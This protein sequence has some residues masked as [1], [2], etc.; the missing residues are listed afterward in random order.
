M[1]LQITSKTL[2]ITG[3]IL[4]MLLQ[5]FSVAIAQEPQLADTT[6][7]CMADS[8]LLDAGDGFISYLWSTDE[9]TQT[10]LAKQPGKYSVICTRQ[11][12]S[13]VEDSTFVIMQNARIDMVDTILTCYSYPVTL[14]V[15]PDTLMYQWTSNDPEL[16][17]PFSTRACVEVTPEK[18]T[19]TLYVQ[20]SDSAN[21]IICTDS[22][23]IWLYPRMVF[24]EVNQINTGCP[25]T[26]KGQLQV[27]V[28]GGLPPYSYVWPTARPVQRDS[29]A[30]SLCESEYTFEV[31][32]Q[33]GCV[34][35]TAI[36]VEVY[37][38]PEVEIVREP[39]NEIYIENPVVD[40]SFNN[41]SIDSLQI[42][43]WSWNFGDSTY[44]KEENPRK[45]FDQVREYEVWLKYT[46][47]NECIDSVSMTVTILQ[48]ELKIPTVITPNGDELNQ[49][50]IIDDLENYISTELKIFNR[51]GRKVYSS[52]NYQSDWDA[53][54]LVEGVYFYVLE[55]KGY[56]S[57]K[58][59]NGT[60]TVMR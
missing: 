49:F 44:T 31:T 41:K 12:M 19:T 53:Q 26:C 43:D 30:F 38:L 20:I 51:L 35:D 52:T 7:V 27:I 46:T 56:F 42:I 3:I 23:Q 28:D 25:G 4:M 47:Q 13:V 34:R 18:D 54:N 36:N 8:V 48:T 24:A 5:F 50:F 55:A 1:A 11:D 39:E 57:T 40:F 10:I 59:F 15:V 16:F 9:Q 17:I 6:R 14:C 45:V 2:P 33:Y 60:I 58:T 29:I 22:V 21:T 32:D 37:D